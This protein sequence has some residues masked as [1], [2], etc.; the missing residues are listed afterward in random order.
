MGGSVILYSRPH[1][2]RQ[3]EISLPSSC[4]QLTQNKNNN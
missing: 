4:F 3:S 1:S 2:R